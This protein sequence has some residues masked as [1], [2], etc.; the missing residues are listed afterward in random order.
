MCW[1]SH[2]AGVGETAGAAC[3]VVH[4]G[5]IAG[6][7]CAADDCRRRCGGDYFKLRTSVA[8]GR[9]EDEV[10]KCNGLLRSS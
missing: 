4:V 3:I 7:A 8:A 5:A 6:A 10:N 9:F 1:T 2:G